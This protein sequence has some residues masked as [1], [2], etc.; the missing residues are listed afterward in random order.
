M[1]LLFYGC[2]FL[3]ML[4][5]I[6]YIGAIIVLF[7]FIVMM[8]N[9]KIIELNSRMI[10]YLP[11]GFFIILIFFIEVIYILNS[12]MSNL[13]SID[14]FTLLNLTEFY[15]LVSVYQNIESISQ[16]LFTK[17]SFMFIMSGFILLVAMLGAI[18]LTL[19]H[20]FIS[21]RQNIYNQINTSVKLSLQLI[22]FKKQFYEK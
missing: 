14:Y 22:S 6:V 17:Y 21:K 12:S 7:L 2:E 4:F 13:I 16:I 10:K 11:I 20:S 18:V 15:R 8:L 5:L 3:A 9:V 19:N 1:L